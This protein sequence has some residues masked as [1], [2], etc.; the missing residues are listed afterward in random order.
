MH[1]KELIYPGMRVAVLG[2]GI[3]GKAAVRYLLKCGAKVIVSDSRQYADL[4]QEEQ[5]LLE[6]NTIPYEGGGHSFTF[7]QDV[8]MVVVSPGIPR[9]LEVLQKVREEK[10]PVLGELAL[11]GPA[12]DV[13]IVAITGTNGKT[14]VTSLIGEI[15]EKAGK[16]VF[17]GGN[18]GT[19][20]FEFLTKEEVVDV[21]V[22]EVSS[23]QLENS[24]SFRPT[25]AL[26]LNVMPDHLDWHGSFEGYVDAKSRIFLHQKKGDAL[27]YCGDD[28][29]CCQIMERFQEKQ[30]FSFGSHASCDARIQDEEI[31]LTW[32]EGPQCY[33][34]SGTSM[35]NHIGQLNSGAAILATLALGCEQANIEKAIHDFLPPPHRME[36]VFEYDGVTYIDDSKATNTGAVISALQQLDNNVILIAGGRDKGDDYSLLISAVEK[37]VRKAI[38]IG[39]SADKIAKSLKGVVPLLFAD[40]MEKAVLLAKE[41]ATVGDTVLLSPACASFDMFESYGQRGDVFAASARKL[42]EECGIAGMEKQ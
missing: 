34:L 3:S 10:I 42:Q 14:T 16:K 26:L 13:P 24:G 12:I 8:K 37:K 33:D 35:D 36:K 9:N 2:L 18:I 17:V 6:D 29:H 41:S 40:S 1:K 19:P 28:P 30:R 25:V 23:F 11:A 39:E 4:S 22:L 38:L 21:V 32:Q 31:C 15:L 7:L 27:I 20:L 5:K